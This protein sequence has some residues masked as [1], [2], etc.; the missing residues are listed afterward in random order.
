MIHVT[1]MRV[2]LSEQEQHQRY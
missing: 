1:S 2:E